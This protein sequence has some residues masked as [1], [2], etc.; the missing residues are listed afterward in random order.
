MISYPDALALLLGEADALESERV[1]IDAVSGRFLASD[2]V[3]PHALPGFD[4]AAMDGFAVRAPGEAIAAGSTYLV[5]AMH[6]AGDD[7]DDYPDAEACEIATGARMPARFDTVVP[8]ERA[9]RQGDR[10]RFVADERRGQNVRRAGSDIDAGTVALTA[11]RRVDPAAIMLLAALGI[12][13]VDVVR[14]PRVAIIN[15][16]S[17][18][19]PGGPLPLAGIHDSNGPFL[20]SSLAR[21]GVEATGR[22]RVADHG[23]AFYLAV[24]DALAAHA[25]LIVTTGAVSA[26]RFD[27]VPAALAS[28]GARELFHKV[29][30]RPGKPLLAACFDRGPLVVAL[31]GNPIAV[32]VGYR[33]FV[34]PVL[35]AMAG[36]APEQPRRARLDVAPST[37]EGLQYFGLGEF[38]HDEGGHPIVRMTPA[39][40]AYRILPYTQANVW[41]SAVEGRVD[42]V[43]TWPLDPTDA[44]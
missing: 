15:T 12:A 22:T 24:R 39:Q 36:L 11:M 21:W 32:A 40:A 20:A 43:D 5:G 2:I 7:T 31:P 42:S 6:A 14:R 35:R 25:D 3:S 30:I 4:N 41:W 38:A 8:V 28:L 37:R 34:A 26:G 44:S 33:F 13:Q 1:D 27:F 17:E 23:D 9:E 29:A 18:L 16:G 10:V 19:N